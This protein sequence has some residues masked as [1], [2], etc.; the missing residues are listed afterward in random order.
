LFSFRFNKS[1]LTN[2]CKKS[3][4]YRKFDKEKQYSGFL[5]AVKTIYKEEGLRG[6]T[7]GARVAVVTVP[8]FYS[9]YFPLYEYMKKFWA[10]KFYNNQG[11]FDAW[12]YT[13]AATSSAL[14]CDLVT[15]PMW[16]VRIRYQTE[17]IQSGSQKMD[18]FNLKKMILK[19]YKK[20]GV[21]VLFRGL[22]ASLLG[23]PHVIIQFNGYEHLKKYFA[24]YYKTSPDF[25]PIQAIFITS[26]VSK[27]NLFLK[28]N[29]V[30]ASF[31]TYPHEVLRNN[32]QNIRN[33]NRKE[34]SLYNISSDIW[35]SQGI[36]GFYSGFQTNL[37]RILP[38]TAIMFMSYEYL[39][40]IL[41]HMIYE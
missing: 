6:F 15:N 3:Y 34:H 37:I 31:C 22:I 11:K 26:I 27:S 2:F 19:L 32:L 23:I 17:F 1:S 5:N 33:Y 18:S 30:F 12:V 20:E 21:L 14:L 41:T 13:F 16:V 25:L 39:S 36:A 10:N 40:K 4:L 28:F 24:K 7:K 8:I 29:L 35:R 9:M 38:A